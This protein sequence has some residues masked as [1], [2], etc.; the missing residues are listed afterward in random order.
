MRRG[1][2]FVLTAILVLLTSARSD[3]SFHLM[4]IVEVF[5]GMPTDPNAQYVMLQMYFPG[6]NFVMGHAV[7]FY[8]ASGTVLGTFT[9]ASNVANGNDLAT[10]LI[11]TSDAETLF[12]VTAD[13]TMMPDIKPDGGA[14][15]FDV[16][17]CVSWGSFSAASAL[18]A[19]SGT[20][21][22]APTGLV[23]GMAMH[24][25]LS[26]GG[27]V[28]DFALAPPA[29]KNNAG[30]T[31]TPPATLTPGAATPTPTPTT[32]AASCIG[33]CDG[34]HTVTVNEII[35][36]VNIALGDAQAAACANG[37]SSGD[38][39]DIT[40]IVQAINNALNGCPAGPVVSAMLSG[41]QETPPVDTA[42]TGTAEFTVSSDGT[43]ITFQLSVTGIDPQ[44]I[45]ASHIHVAPVGVSEP[46]VVPLA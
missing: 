14:V 7:S 27:T 45:T 46:I 39:V 31:G 38:P 17:D 22:N 13:L 24:R 32:A 35:T 3:A 6:E 10:I 34:S 44:Q 37:I 43:M 26:S 1:V 28:T 36:L 4:K 16:I 21:F 11:A 20:P 29:P 9:F 18:P 23:S 40:L 25:D 33:D 41:D 12:S 2:L 15:C 8:D 30:Q 19:P 42:A 5:P